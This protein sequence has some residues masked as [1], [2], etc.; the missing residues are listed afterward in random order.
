[1]EDFMKLSDKEIMQLP[2]ADEKAEFIG[3]GSNE[4]FKD[5]EDEQKGIRGIFGIRHE[6]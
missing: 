2:D 6:K 5:F 1:M 3:P 4:E